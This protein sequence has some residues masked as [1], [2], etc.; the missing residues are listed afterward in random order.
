MNGGVGYT[1]VWV[2]CLLLTL[3]VIKTRG[4]SLSVVRVIVRKIR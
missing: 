2:I 3:V 4:C 1:A